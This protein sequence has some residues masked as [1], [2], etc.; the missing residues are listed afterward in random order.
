LAEDFDDDGR[1][2]VAVSV[3]SAF[4]KANT[5]RL[6]ALDDDGELLWSPLGPQA[7][8]PAVKLR[9]CQAAGCCGQPTPTAA[10]LKPSQRRRASSAESSSSSLQ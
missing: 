2:E 1:L 4:P 3:L 8:H 10:Q 6:V 9:L 7:R 5:G